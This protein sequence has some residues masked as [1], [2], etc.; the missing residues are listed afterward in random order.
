MGVQATNFDDAPQQI[1][2]NRKAATYGGLGAMAVT[3]AN[4]FTNHQGDYVKS[5][6]TTGDGGA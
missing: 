3:I 1:L 5:L 2:P 6:L 4:H